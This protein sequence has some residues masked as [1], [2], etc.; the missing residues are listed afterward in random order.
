MKRNFCFVL[1]GTLLDC[2]DELGARYQLPVYVLSMP[3]NMMED[4]GSAAELANDDMLAANSGQEITVKFR[5]THNNKDVKLV[6]RTTD[7]VSKVKRLIHDQEKVEPHRQ[8]W[9]Y[10]G[11]LIGNKLKIEDAKI[12]K[13]SLVQVLVTIPTEPAVTTAAS[14]AAST[15]TTATTASA[16]DSASAGSMKS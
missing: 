4:T 12:T 16:Q 13:G 3:T 8:R 7:S 9:C 15:A 14:T 2:Y 1:P 6:C 11:R 5:F 10:G